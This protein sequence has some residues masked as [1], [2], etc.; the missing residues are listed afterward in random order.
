MR[1]FMSEDFLLGGEVARLLFHE[2]AESMPIFDFHTHLPAED[3]A[4]DRRFD[5]LTQLWLSWDHYKW[6]A[7]RASGVPEEFITGTASDEQK[8]MAWAETLPKL[9]GNPLFHWT[10][11]ELKRYFGIS[12]KMLCPETAP[13][14][15][16][17][18]NELLKKEEFSAR[19]LVARAKV[20]VLFTTDDPTS[21]LRFH[22]LLKEDKKFGVCIVLT[23][24]PD[25]A[26]T[27][28]QPEFFVDWINKLERAAEEEITTYSSFVRA[29]E[30]R[31]ESFHQLG[32]RS[33]DHA[34]DRP[35]SQDYDPEQLERIFQK[36]RHKRRLSLEE[37]AKFK[38]GV[39]V[40]LCKMNF[41]RGWVQ[42]FHIGAIRNVNTRGF[43][44]LGPDAGYDA[45]GDEPLAR[46]LARFMDLLERAGALGK[47]ILYP[48]NPKDAE[49]MLTIA[50]CFQDGA[51]PGKIQLGPPCWFNDQ[52]LGIRHQLR[53]IGSMGVMGVFIGMVTDSRSFLSF[54]R[55]EYFRRILC[56][57]LGEEVKKGNFPKD[58]R[59]LG[60]LVR[61][62]CY[63][64]A[65]KYFEI[66]PKEL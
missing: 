39:L 16:R 47:T 46:D 64:N 6:R 52:E 1:E 27:V 14:I 51:T 15:Y 59:L 44:L 41:K 49:V 28:H 24:R 63:E 45:M 43:R 11:L 3:I 48:I 58:E 22:R 55:H 54:P 8:F 36:V 50:G 10:H 57:E 21:D 60:E 40:E 31:H 66:Y 38:T 20:K 13:E 42:Q 34:L 62:I 4:I 25:G 2:F 5:N 19:H 65:Q 9:V 29:L 37:E 35:Y 30:K 33:S 56:D 61:G 23:F 32:C 12:G 7:M 17:I 26:I 53:L 18:C